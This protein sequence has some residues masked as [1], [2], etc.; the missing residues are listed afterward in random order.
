MATRE[1]FKIEGLRELEQALAELPKAT[2]KNVLKRALLKAGAPIASM[3]ASLAPFLRGK[4]RQSFGTGTKLSRRQRREHKQ[5]STVEVFAGPGALVQAITQEFGTRNHRPQPFM[6]PAWDAN[7]RQALESVK[8]ELAE[9]IEKTRQRAAR[10]AQ[11]EIAKM[12]RG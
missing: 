11:R 6:R 12:R 3:A 4:L 5:E 10:K 8:D 2:G 1:R 9:E 7:K